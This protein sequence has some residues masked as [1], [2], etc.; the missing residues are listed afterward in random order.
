MVPVKQQFECWQF[1]L[2]LDALLIKFNSKNFIKPK[3]EIKY[4]FHFSNVYH[5]LPVAMVAHHNKIAKI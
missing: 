3:G 4:Y 2:I 5:L 1:S